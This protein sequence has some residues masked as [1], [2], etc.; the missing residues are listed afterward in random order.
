M[1]SDPIDTSATVTLDDLCEDDRREIERKLEELRAETLKQYF[2]TIDG[3]VKKVT[4]PTP[5][6]V[7]DTQVQ[8]SIDDGRLI[9]TENTDKVEIDINPLP[10]NGIDFANKKV[11]IRSDQAEST[12]EKKC[13]N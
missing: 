2:K 7:L 5:S 6:P 11:L 1:N 8:S 3:V 12:K 10:S 13:S 4:T 9:F